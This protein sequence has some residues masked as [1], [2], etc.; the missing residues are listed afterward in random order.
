[1]PK[2]VA[3]MTKEIARLQ[4]QIESVKAKEIQGV[5]QRIREA[6]E[7]YG[8]TPG[9]LFSEG[10][11]ATKNRLKSGGASGVSKPK[12]GTKKLSKL[13]SPAPG[14]SPA[15]Y[16]DGLGRTWSGRGR[17]PRWLKEA[18]ASG[19]PKEHFATDN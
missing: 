3:Q 8:L 13:N 10:S 14:K 6:I 4:S 9:Q 18:I 7:Y 19:K 12:T 15:K 2:T 1:M 5:V 11:Q 17:P 16:A